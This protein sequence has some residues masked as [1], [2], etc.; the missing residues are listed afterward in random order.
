MKDGFKNDKNYE[1]QIEKSLRTENENLIGSTL[2]N[3]KQFR[4]LGN[5]LNKKINESNDISHELGDKF[6]K[7]NK[8]IRGNMNNLTKVLKDKNS[9]VCWSIVFIFVIVFFINKLYFKNNNQSELGNNIK[10]ED[11]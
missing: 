7:T 10:I 2:A 4:E 1:K 5:T 9:K 11:N 6:D 3:M 8:G